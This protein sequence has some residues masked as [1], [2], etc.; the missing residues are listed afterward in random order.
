MQHPRRRAERERIHPVLRAALC[1][2]A[3][4]GAVSSSHAGQQFDTASVPSA[5]QHHHEKFFFHGYSTQF[6]CDALEGEVRRI[7]LFVGARAT[8]SVH[9]DCP[10]GHY[11]PDENAWVTVDFDTLVPAAP[12]AG[13]AGPTVPGRWVH[14]TLEPRHPIFMQEGDCFLIEDMKPLLTSGFTSQGEMRVQ[15]DCMPHTQILISYDVEGEVLAPEHPEVPRPQLG[16][17][18]GK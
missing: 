6:N 16:N 9:A 10:R 2:A 7:L 17:N 4:G 15:T 11:V 12:G 1:L 13:D 8:A 3:L 14:K 18:S 5:W